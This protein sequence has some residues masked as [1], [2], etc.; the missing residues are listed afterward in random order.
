[1]AKKVYTLGLNAV[2]IGEVGLASTR[3]A[4]GLTYQD[5]CKLTQD[6][7]ETTD[8][9]AE[10]EDDPVVSISRAGKTVVEFDLMDPSPDDMVTLMGGAASKSSAGLS[11]N[12]VWSA[13]AK[14][15]SIYKSLELDPEQGLNIQISRAKIEAKINGE[16]SKKGMTLV[17]VKATVSKPDGTD[18][19]MKASVKA[20]AAAAAAASSD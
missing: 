16:F 3:N 4:I 14:A 8:F 9:Y 1:M 2:K 19:K 5:S 17:H 12:D 15:P 6:D 18:A 7:A 11:D 13:P 20:A 10:E